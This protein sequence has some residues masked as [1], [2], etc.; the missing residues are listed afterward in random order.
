MNIRKI[1][2][3][4]LMITTLVIPAHAF[5]RG[6]SFFSPRPQGTHAERELIGWQEEINIYAHGINYGS[7]SIMPI[8]SRSIKAE[9]LAGYFFGGDE[10]VVSGSQSK[11]R[12]SHDLMADYFGLP[13]DYKSTISFKPR[14]QNIMLDFGLY[15]GLDELYPGLYVRFH[16]P[17]VN[18]L[19]NLNLT[20]CVD[21][22]GTST[23]PAGYMASAEITRSSMMRTMT[24]WFRGCKT[25][26]DLQPLV[27]GKIDGDHN[28]FG[29][30]DIQAALGWNFISHQDYH[31]GMNLRTVIPTGNHSLSLVLFEPMV[32]NG[33]HWEFGLGFTGH[34]FV[35][36]S[37]NGKHSCAIYGDLN[38][39]HLF[40]SRQR[41]SFDFRF[42][43]AV[44]RYI[45]LEA[46]GNP[47]VEGLILGE[48]LDPS[49]LPI[50]DAPA[51]Q[52][53]H[54]VL[55]PAVNVTTFDANVSV[56]LQADFVLKIAYF[57]EGLNVDL[58]YN[59]WART[60]ERIARCA[61]LPSN[62]FAIKGDAQVYGFTEAPAEFVAL[63][64]TQ[65]KATLFAGQ[66]TGNV[67]FINTNADNPA[68]AF[69]GATQL[70]QATG[71]FVYASKQAILLSDNDIDN[72][73]AASPASISQTLFFH[74]AYSWPSCMYGSPYVGAGAEYTVDGSG[75]RRHTA[76]SEWALWI[77]TGVSF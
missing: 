58:G 48:P 46:I 21:T 62:A 41:R 70:T 44:S 19:W 10:F 36:D 66:G 64:A 47:V 55:V 30:A 31:F 43:G 28:R 5:M 50:P 63:N 65:S 53:Y 69:F 32:G 18:T 27:Y 26:G 73:S 12:G 33:G 17:L 71:D 77:K 13:T 39:T 40:P 42:N 2:H 29:L 6:R 49:S 34:A 9:E 72:L 24:E 25:V 20:E 52:Q 23:Y 61:S 4:I 3:L 51:Q 16:A 57:Y 74:T 67:D 54:S 68:Q 7:F 1:I 56:A 22:L 45:T 60:A 35:W 8:Y 37:C 59:L 38:V 15:F 14:I 75:S 11:N 76:L